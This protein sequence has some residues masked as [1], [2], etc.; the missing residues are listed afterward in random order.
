MKKIAA[1]LTA[2]L[3]LT[4]A[5][6]AVDAPGT[7]PVEVDKTDATVIVFDGDTTTVTGTGA[8]AN[9]TDV[10]ISA[11]GTYAVRGETDDGRIVVNAQ[12]A[13]VTVILD[14][15][16]I[17]C[18]DASA[19]CF[20]R[21]KNAAVCAKDGTNNT[22]SDGK[23]YASDDSFSSEDTVPDACLYADADL[24]LT[25]GGTLTVSGNAANAIKAK[26][27]VLLDALTLTVNA[28]DKGV[29]ADTDITVNGGRYTF[30]CADDALHA[31]RDLT[32]KSGE[33]TITS[34][35]DAIHAE[36]RVEILGG[37]LQITAHEGVEGTLV[38]IS[39]GKLSVQA[40]DDG[41]N[42]AHKMDG[43]TPTVKINGE[44]DYLPVDKEERLDHIKENW[45]DVTVTKVTLQP[46][47]EGQL[48]ALKIFT[49]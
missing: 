10:I 9:G 39:G 25:G 18:A 46:Q 37:D 20:Y 40:S 6:C 42:A 45:Q 8:S 33:I 24:T 23:R 3:M 7:Q 13:D 17:A 12:G 15:A 2:F 27:A 49:D 19:V 22:L 31:D 38:T 44:Y 28:A 34:G 48:W 11:G 43:V 32:V 16:Q 29:K 1:F 14:G 36:N 21:A 41:I 47:G 4:L 30:D 35:D 26:G 5:S